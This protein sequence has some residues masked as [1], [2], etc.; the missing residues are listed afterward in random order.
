M[1]RCGTSSLL[2]LLLVLAL[3]V[4]CQEVLGNDDSDV[5]AIRRVRRV[6]EVADLLSETIGHKEHEAAA[7][8]VP[9]AV[10]V[11]AAV[12]LLR[13]TQ[14]FDQTH[15]EAAEQVLANQEL[16][17]VLQS[18]SF[19]MPPTNP[20][21]PPI[22]PLETPVPTTSAPV[23]PPPVVTPTDAPVVA[24]TNAPVVASTPAPVVAP[25]NAPVVVPMNT[26][27]VAPTNAPV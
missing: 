25:T 4:S 7:A 1:M 5:A 18:S 10:P 21:N 23:D 15:E 12:L 8:A 11:P 24:P 19:S 13:R 16:Y 17:R 26:P 3:V 14:T 2:L 9:A 20:T 6:V 27:V 22:A